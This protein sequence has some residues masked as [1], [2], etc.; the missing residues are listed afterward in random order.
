[1]L[2]KHYGTPFIIQCSRAAYTD[3]NTLKLSSICS[4]C[5]KHNLIL[6]SSNVA[7]QN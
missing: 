4:D 1:M 6:L 2:F 3:P 5:R 7:P